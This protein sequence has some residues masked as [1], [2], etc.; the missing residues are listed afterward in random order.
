[1]TAASAIDP[2]IDP[3]T[4]FSA[5]DDLRNPTTAEIDQALADCGEQTIYFI[6]MGDRGPIKIGYTRS[7]K[8]LRA[9]IAALQTGSPFPLHLRRAATGT[10]NT[11]RILHQFFRHLHMSGEWFWPNELLAHVA[12]ANTVWPEAYED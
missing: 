8:N 7:E 3:H 9:R 5:I 6:Q 11:E 10:R 12:W 1:M 2:R 4:G